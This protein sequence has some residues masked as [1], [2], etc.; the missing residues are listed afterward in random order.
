MSEEAH[1]NIVELEGGTRH[2]EWPGNSFIQKK[3]SWE[4]MENR[5]NKSGKTII[6]FLLQY[7]KSVYHLSGSPPVCELRIVWYVSHR[8]WISVAS[9]SYRKY[10]P[11]W[12]RSKRLLLSTCGKPVNVI[13]NYIFDHDEISCCNLICRRIFPCQENVPLSRKVTLGTAIRS[14]DL[15]DALSAETATKQDISHRRGHKSSS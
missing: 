11:A 5:L 7:W 8:N 10:H 9:K 15:Q 6:F 1:V 13:T 2:F 4:N 12:E 3:S 14:P